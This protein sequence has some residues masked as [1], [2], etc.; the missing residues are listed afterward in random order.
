MSS[1]KLTLNQHTSINDVNKYF[2]NF[3]ANKQ[4]RARKIG[5]GQIELYVRKDSFK[6]FFTDKLRPDFLVKR[7]YQEARKIILEKVNQ[8]A[9]EN[10][11]LTCLL[12]IKKNFANHKSH[13]YPRELR[14]EFGNLSQFLEKQAGAKE[15]IESIEGKIKIT[16]GNERYQD[17][18]TFQ[19]YVI[20]HQAFLKLNLNEDETKAQSKHLFN[21]L[22][23]K[24][25]LQKENFNENDVGNSAPPVFIDYEA[26]INLG[27]TWQAA[28]LQR[29]SSQKKHTSNSFEKLTFNDDYISNLCKEIFL[30]NTR[31]NMKENRLNNTP[32]QIE[33]MADN[34]NNTIAACVFIDS[35]NSPLLHTQL[36]MV[37]VDFSSK[38]IFLGDTGISITIK[39]KTSFAGYNNI[40]DLFKIDYP[41]DRSSVGNH[42]DDIYEVIFR[43]TLSRMPPQ[44]INQTNAPDAALLAEM[45][46]AMHIPILLLSDSAEENQKQKDEILTSFVS[47]TR[48][49]T[50]EQPHLRINVQLPKGISTEDVYAAYARIQ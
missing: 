33:L 23:K 40:F 28:V 50:R 18:Q 34:V 46:I 49:L 2:E 42:L 37:P 25:A 12:N 20:N 31:Q 45:P 16:D 43:E 6:Q 15:A 5:G 3:D 24:N 36:S 38:V 41:D 11:K 48:K 30:A 35:D 21:F 10:G 8:S 14:Q 13:F 1:D 4:V 26:I 47:A 19:D 22:E 27:C 7:D 32:I 9:P 39:D 29:S 44:L 17:L